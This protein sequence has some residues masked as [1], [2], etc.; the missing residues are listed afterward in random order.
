MSE[1][2]KDIEFAKLKNIVS[3]N[4]KFNSRYGLQYF[5]PEAYERFSEQLS[6]CRKNKV[7][8]QHQHSNIYS[9]YK[10]NYQNYFKIRDLENAE[11]RKIA[12][13]FIG[14]KKI[15]LFILNRDKNKCLKCGS[16]HRLQLDH[17]VPIS[18]GGENKISNL[19][20]L[21]GSC[22]SKKRDNYKDYR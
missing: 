1:E 15:R 11:P 18:K 22:N 4:I 20:T 19:Q 8:D 12:Q 17:I 21:C 10:H 9:Y 16:E 2:E 3:V 14:K 7:L 5:T 6:F 13:Q